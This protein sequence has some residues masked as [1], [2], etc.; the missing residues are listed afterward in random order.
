LADVILRQKGDLLKAE[1]LARETL[2]I[3]TLIHS[4]DDLSIGSSCDLLARI[5]M[6]QGTFE[7]ETKRLFERSL[8]IFIRREGPDGVNTAIL[9]INTGSYFYKLVQRQPTVDTKRKYFLLSMSHIEEGFRIQTKIYG[10]T[11]PITVQA[12]YKLSDVMNEHQAFLKQKESLK[13]VT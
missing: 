8:A 12:A 4:S 5:L 2:R 7:D 1:K 9:N 10:P 3:R 13:I 6:S 11:H